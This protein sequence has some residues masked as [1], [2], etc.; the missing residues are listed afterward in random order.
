MERREVLE[1]LLARHPDLSRDE[2]EVAANIGAQ[3][4]HM[5]MAPLPIVVLRRIRDIAVRREAK[6]VIE[7]GAGTDPLDADSDDDG[8]SDGLELGLTAGVDPG[9][10][11]GGV[12]FK[13]S[14]GF[15]GDADPST[16][17]D[18]TKADSDGG[19]L[20]DGQEDLDGDGEV[21]VGE[22]DPNVAADDTDFDG[23]GIPDDEEIA[24]GSDPESADSDGDGLDDVYVPMPGGY[25]NRLYLRRPDGTAQEVSA[26]AEVD[27]LDNVRAALILDLDED[28]DQD[29]AMSVGANIVLCWNDGSGRLAPKV[30]RAA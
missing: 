25:P 10:S 29:L 14:E 19:G 16:T 5:G 6:H 20:E 23:D 13:G 17:T 15:Q 12:A 18:P 2:P 9:I 11:E 26:A 22:R 28:G 30:L 3:M 24:N 21:D 4:S 27:W 1:A 8:L 7:V